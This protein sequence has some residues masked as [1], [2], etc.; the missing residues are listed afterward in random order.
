M[1][2]GFE[3]IFHQPQHRL[4]QGHMV[5]LKELAAL[6]EKHFMGMFIHDI[7]ILALRCAIKSPHTIARAAPW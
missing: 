5:G 4:I 7:L 3:K 2:V 1:V 6:G